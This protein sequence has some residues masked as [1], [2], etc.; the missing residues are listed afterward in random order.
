MRD[1]ERPH[2]GDAGMVEQHDVDL[3]RADLFAAAV[4]LLLQPP[5][6]EQVAVRVEPPLVAGAEP[7]VGERLGVR[8]RIVVVARRHV[9]AAD[10]HLARA[11]L[12]QN[13]AVVVHHDN[14]LWSSSDLRRRLKDG[15]AVC[16]F[17]SAA[18]VRLPSSATAMK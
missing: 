10:H 6:Q 14:D 11:A 5:G 17:F 9:G 7:A 15:C 8:L 13:G 4:D 2:L 16:S 3:Q 18:T 1:A 12:R